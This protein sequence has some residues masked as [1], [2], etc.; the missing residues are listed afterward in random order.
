LGCRA[1]LL[2]RRVEITVNYS[3]EP[4]ETAA[5]CILICQSRPLTERVV[6]HYDQI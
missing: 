4:G 5:G 3:L 1:K 6:A 2:E